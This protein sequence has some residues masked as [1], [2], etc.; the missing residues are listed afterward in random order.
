MPKW[1]SHRAKT[2]LAPKGLK[3]NLGSF[4]PFLIYSVISHVKLEHVIFHM[5]IW[6]MWYLTCEVSLNTC[7]IMCFTCEVSHVNLEHVISHMWSFTCEHMWNYIYV[8]HMW[9]FTCEISYVK[10]HMFQIHMWNFTH[11]KSCGIFLRAM[12]SLLDFYKDVTINAA[13]ISDF[14]HIISHVFHITSHVKFH[15]W[16]ITCSKF[17]CEISHMWN[18]VE[19]F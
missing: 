17:I 12:K 1:L 16:K 8:F 6:N 13:K 9:N 3:R 4:W 14:G 7:E 15:M 18:H 19:F 10:F 11:V 5:C 2:A